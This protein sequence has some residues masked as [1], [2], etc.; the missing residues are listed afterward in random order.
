[1]KIFNRMFNPLRRVLRQNLMGFLIGF[2]LVM[3]GVIVL[4]SRIILIVPGGNLA[5]LYRPLA[6]GIDLQRVYREGV[7]VIFPWDSATQYDSRVQVHTVDLKLLTA[8]QLEADVTITFQYEINPTTVPLL[9]KYAGPSYL[10]KMIVPQVVSIV[11][12]MVAKYSSKNAYTNGIQQ[13]IKDIAIT[14]DSVIIDELSPPGLSNIRLIHIN[15]VQLAAITYPP[16]VRTAIQNKMI[17]AQNA[18]AVKFKI[19]AADLEATRKTI[20]A[21]GIKNFQDIAFQGELESYLRYRGI[22]AT[23]SLAKSENAKVLLFG[24]GSSGLPLV[25]GDINAKQPTPLK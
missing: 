19:E 17:E 1:M 9:H 10:Q 13:V 7:H 12:E 18:E 5:V 23:E 11:R 16:D 3:A 21:R 4:W 2:L 6:G 8:D 20:E 25:L 14:A 15:A 24:S 22:E